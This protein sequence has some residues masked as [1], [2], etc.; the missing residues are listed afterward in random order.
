[1]CPLQDSVVVPAVLSP[2]VYEYC[3]TSSSK[4]NLRAVYDL[5]SHKPPQVKPPQVKVEDE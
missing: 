3:D 2:Q 5:Q 4:H 1:M